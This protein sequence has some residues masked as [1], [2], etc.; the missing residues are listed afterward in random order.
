MIFAEIN[1]EGFIKSDGV[2]EISSSGT[3]N[4]YRKVAIL[5]FSKIIAFFHFSVVGMR[6]TDSR[7]RITESIAGNDFVISCHIKRG[8]AL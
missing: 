5:S 4:F 3:C 7:N 6:R 2:P 1:K 8:K